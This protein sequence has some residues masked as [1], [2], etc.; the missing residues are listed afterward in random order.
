MQPNEKQHESNITGAE[1]WRDNVLSYGIDEATIICRNYLDMNLKREHSDDEGQFCRELF[2]AMFN[3]TAQKVEPNKLI[4]PYDLETADKRTEEAYYH[5]SR[6]QN[7]KCATGIDELIRDSRYETNF[8]NLELAAMCAIMDYGFPRV[9]S[10]LA[11]NFQNIGSDGRYSAENRQWSYSFFV[12]KSA[13]EKTWLKAHAIVINGFCDYVRELY[14][15]LDAER[16]ALPGNEESGEFEGNV[17]VKRAIIT[18]HDP[19]VDNGEGFSTGYAIGH[20]PKAVNPYV[21]WQ[22]A[23]R[24]GERHYNIG[25]YGNDEQIAIDS[26]LARVF[27]ALN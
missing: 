18:F 25:D 16:Y 10:V 1:M 3:A 11:F 27:V 5:L 19:R 7:S 9:C 4:Y 26:Y 17:E 20:N 12:Q 2:H 23:V 8:Y 21:C 14:Q 15:N 13:F 6:L 22:F 24:S